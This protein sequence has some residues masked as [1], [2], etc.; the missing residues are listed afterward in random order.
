MPTGVARASI[1]LAAGEGRRYRQQ[2]G[3]D[4]LLVSSRRDDPA[5]PVVLLASMQLFAGVCERCVVVLPA[6]N[7]ERL[8]LVERH[9]AEL[10]IEWLVVNTD[11]LGHSLAQAV[12]RIPVHAGWL[13][14]LADMP[15]VQRKTLEQLAAALRPETLLVPTH[16]NRRGHP[17]AIG[18][19]YFDVLRQLD[20]DRGAQ[21]LFASAQVAELLVEDAG[22]AL[23]IDTPADRL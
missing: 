15:Y 19:A 5:S 12:E 2:G 13:V 20:G 21:A 23:D 10:G 14:G 4:K 17:R 16:A 7:P 6:G 11:G 22:I 3:E 8:E 1:L 18:A 9:A